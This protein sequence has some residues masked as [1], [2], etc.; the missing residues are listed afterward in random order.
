MSR[1][2]RRDSDRRDLSDTGS[3]SEATK[4]RLEI[5]S[6]G[7]VTTLLLNARFNRLH[8]HQSYVP[9]AFVI[10]RHPRD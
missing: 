9:W 5:T 6:P 7:S 8:I 4:P 1:Q 10:H 2:T 3:T